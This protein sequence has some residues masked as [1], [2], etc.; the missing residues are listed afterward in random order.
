MSRQNYNPFSDDFIDEYMEQCYPAPAA[1][2]ES[3]DTVEQHRQ[4]RSV[5]SS[6]KQPDV[7]NPHPTISALMDRAA[8][9]KLNQRLQLRQEQEDERQ[10]KKAERIYGSH[11]SRSH[12]SKREVAAAASMLAAPLVEPELPIQKVV[13]KSPLAPP[14]MRRQMM[15]QKQV[16]AVSKPQSA[17]GK[18]SCWSLLF[19]L[20]SAA[21]AGYYYGKHGADG[22]SSY[23]DQAMSMITDFRPTLEQFQQESNFNM[24]EPEDA[25]RWPNNGQGLDLKILFAADE[26]W[27][28][29]FVAAVSDWNNC[30]SLSLTTENV[31]VDPDCSPVDGVIKVCNK[32]WGSTGWNGINYAMVDSDGYIASSVANMNEYYLK[33]SRDPQ[34]QYVMCHE[35]GHGE[36]AG[37]MTDDGAVNRSEQCPHALNLT[38]TV[39]SLLFI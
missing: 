3:V 37:M 26:K 35:M 21:A 11:K 29:Y 20:V 5:N 15:M 6:S 17:N 32:D 18:N 1:S 16:A 38:D 24:T 4:L 10:R 28:K 14:L 22:V 25:D 8:A 33:W 36:Y 31:T 7:V 9:D 23:V 34:K 27:Y 39:L 30:S 19:V 13:R 2:D 12:R